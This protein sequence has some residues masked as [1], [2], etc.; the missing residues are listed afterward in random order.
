MEKEKYSISIDKLKHKKYQLLTEGS[1]A[2][3]KTMKDLMLAA[4]AVG[5]VNNTSVPIR[6]GAALKIFEWGRFDPVDQKF[7]S[8]LTFLKSK[9]VNDVLDK[10]K[11]IE[12]L[13]AYA[14]GGFDEIYDEITKK[15]NRVLNLVSHVL[16]KYDGKEEEE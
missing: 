12:T 4:A 15:G 8:S 14:N 7:V 10:E 3:F 16:S 5:F 2:P 6:T 13:Q 9:D 1:D 11:L